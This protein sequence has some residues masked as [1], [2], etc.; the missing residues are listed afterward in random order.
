M[1]GRTD[2]VYGMLEQGGVCGRVTLMYWDTAERLTGLDRY[3]I[4]SRF[5][6]PAGWNEGTTI[7]EYL[8]MQHA[9]DKVIRTG[10]TIH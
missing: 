1:F 6:E 4:K 3:E 8:A 2:L 10:H 9:E 7:H 5:D